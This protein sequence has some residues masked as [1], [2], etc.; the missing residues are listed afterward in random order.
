MA[1]P[2]KVKFE[3]CQKLLHSDEILKCQ[4]CKKKYHY[5]CVSVSVTSFKDLTDQYKGS[6]L[7]PACSRPKADNTNTPIRNA[8]SSGSCSKLSTD[9]STD[10]GTDNNVTIRRKNTKSKTST[11][12]PECST[13]ARNVGRQ[14]YIDD[15]PPAINLDHFRDIIH[16]EVQK[17][18]THCINTY[19]CPQLKEIRVEIAEYKKS[20][21]FF[22]E[23]L[24]EF[25]K[26]H[27]NH[28]E[29]FNTL[30]NDNSLLKSQVASLTQRIS[31]ME[32]QARSSNI[33][34]QCLPESKSENLLT[35][36][37][38]LG[39]VV[40]YPLTDDNI[41]YCARTAKRNAESSRPRSVV[42]KLNS[43]RVRDNLLA[44]CIQ[45]NKI[46]ANE[47]LHSGLLGYGG[48]MKTPIFITEHLTPEMKSLHAAAR[49]K[50]KEYQYRFVWIRNGRIYMRKTETSEYIYVK[51]MEC[52]SRLRQGNTK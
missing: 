4:T 13:E 44:A 22:S 48:S 10:V 52:L 41:L 23:K 24:E 50:A 30:T 16:A 12:S 49:V 51:N 18:V 32:Q 5:S 42:I 40:K 14:E 35:V 39:E 1:P 6:W 31:Q 9:N 36:V 34:L 20:V 25:Q 33:E 2:Q 47:K 15:T 46:N 27:N 37:K 7:C 19:L 43:P 17:A 26:W 29:S 3:C 45:F 8:P 11:P 28:V 38:K 21:D